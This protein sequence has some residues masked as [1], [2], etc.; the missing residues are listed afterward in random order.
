MTER[1]LSH[2]SP[3]IAANRT[4][5]KPLI[6]TAAM[7][8]ACIVHHDATHKDGPNTVKWFWEI[9]E[10]MGKK[11]R[12]LLLKFMSG[13]SRLVPGSRYGVTM[14]DGSEFPEGHTCGLSMDVPYFED[15]AKM[16]RNLLTA[17][18]LCGEIDLDGDGGY[19][20]EGA[21]SDSGAD[22]GRSY[23][24][25]DENGE[26]GSLASRSDRSVEINIG[27]MNLP[28]YQFGNDAKAKF[29]SDDEGVM[30]P[31]ESC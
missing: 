10:E 24:S 28:V 13:D 14:R 26:F 20:S 8:K 1:L 21:S 12:E 17:F 27:R 3:Q 6:T 4:S 31:S 5:A 16:Q 25:D 30:N 9:F 19:G 23:N 7:R 2:I 18:R 11:D 22:E 29:C 15:K